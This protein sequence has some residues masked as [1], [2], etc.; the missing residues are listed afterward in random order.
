MSCRLLLLQ[1]TIQ[2]APMNIVFVCVHQCACPVLLPCFF[3]FVEISWHKWDPDRHRLRFKNHLLPRTGRWDMFRSVSKPGGI[4]APAGPLLS[5][6]GHQPRFVRPVGSSLSTWQD[7]RC[8]GAFL[9]RLC[10][11][12]EWFNGDIE[13][14]SWPSGGRK[15]GG[16]HTVHLA[17]AAH[18]SC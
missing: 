17:S 7:V 1:L 10:Y 18:S 12:L 3:H 11:A 13:R 15:S 2:C 9:W 4:A 16:D 14:A 8:K 6:E 5:A